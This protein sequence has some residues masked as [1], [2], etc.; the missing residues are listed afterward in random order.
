MP[1]EPHPDPNIVALGIRQPWVELILRGIKTIEVR[2]QNTQIRGPIYLYAAKKLSEMP[3]T[4]S[5]A[6][7]YDLNL[8][9]LPRGVVVGSVELGETR[10]IQSDDAIAAC[11]PRS[12]LND[13]FAWKLANPVRFETPLTVLFLPYGV[14][15]YPWKR[16]PKKRGR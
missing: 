7:K 6:A 5:V 2:T 11:V 4:S 12:I 3:A 10:P 16:R 9:E 8:N 1:R 14:W 15:F 13:Q